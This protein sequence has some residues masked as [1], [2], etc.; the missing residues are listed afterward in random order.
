MSSLSVWSHLA[1]QSSV[2]PSSDEMG[3]KEPDFCLLSRSCLPQKSKL[4]LRPKKWRVVVYT[5]CTICIS[6]T[7]HLFTRSWGDWVLGKIGQCI[8]PDIKESMWPISHRR[9]QSISDSSP[10]TL[11]FF[12]LHSGWMFCSLATA[13]R[14]FV[15]LVLLTFVHHL[16]SSLRKRLE[17]EVAHARYKSWHYPIRE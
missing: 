10:V 13:T 5:Q 17:T 11:H 12:W 16:I 1:L 9:Q 8:K 7:I 3:K 4:F 14:L 2:S 6:R 15:Y